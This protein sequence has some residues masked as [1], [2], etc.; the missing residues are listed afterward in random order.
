M[1]PLPMAP[2]LP[3]RKPPWLKV[4][5]PSGERYVRLKELFRRLDL[6]TVCEEARC[7]NIGECWGGGTATLMLLGDVCTRGCRFCNVRTGNPRG[8]VDGREPEKVA[9]ALAAIGLDYV[10]L[11]MVDRDDLPDGGAAHVARTV[12]EIKRRDPSILVELLTGDFAG[13]RAAIE[14]VARAGADVL[15]HNVETVRRLTPAVRD[16]RAT[17]ERSLGVLDLF[18]ELAPARTAVKSALMLGLGETEAE[19]DETLRDL[20]ARPRATEIVHV[21]QYLRPSAWHLPVVEYVAPERFEALRERALALGFAYVAAGPLVRSS[22]RAGE[23]FLRSRLA[24][25]TRSAHRN[26]DSEAA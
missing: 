15:S 20:R 17:Y 25:R 18:R 13:E 12:A 14:V 21:G 8:V 9:E 4:R 16:R 24:S 23:L 5:A 7:P 10:V 26:A 1:L 2:P 6:H 3:D 22:Y 19:V 11:T